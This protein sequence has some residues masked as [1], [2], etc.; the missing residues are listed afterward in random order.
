MS[1]NQRRTISAADRELLDALDMLT[2]QIAYRAEVLPEQDAAQVV[3]DG[4]AELIPQRV[5]SRAPLGAQILAA[6]FTVMVHDRM[7]RPPA[8]C[9]RVAAG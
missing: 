7:A 6:R 4:V 8:Q 3:A 1:A 5:R 9:A 2:Q